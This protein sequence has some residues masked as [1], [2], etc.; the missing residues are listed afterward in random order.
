MSYISGGLRMYQFFSVQ[1]R[2]PKKRQSHNFNKLTWTFHIFINNQILVKV[3][4]SR[5][6]GKNHKKLAFDCTI[7]FLLSIDV[8]PLFRYYF[9]F[10][11]QYVSFSKKYWIISNSSVIF[12]HI[13][14][15]ISCKELDWALWIIVF[16]SNPK[17]MFNGV[18]SGD[19][20]C[21]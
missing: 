2:E 8:P 6:K 4:S 7:I 18:R 19:L 11:S 5:K 1:L 17:R 10:S 9:N 12:Y 15:R 21:H 20:G 14:G 3:K 16:N 13:F